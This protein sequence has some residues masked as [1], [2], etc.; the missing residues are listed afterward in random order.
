[1]LERVYPPPKAKPINVS[2]PPINA[3]RDALAAIAS[4][5]TALREG[6]LTPD[7]TNALSSVIG[8]FIQ[9]IDLQDHERRIAAL[10]QA[11]GK[12]DEKDN[13]PAA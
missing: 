5:C 6:G 4:I 10:E 1:M 9:L 3:P 8:R 2:M 11:R 13:P 12:R 7:E